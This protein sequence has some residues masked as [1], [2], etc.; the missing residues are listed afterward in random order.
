MP[1]TADDT[2]LVSSS[3]CEV[4]VLIEIAQKDANIQ[5]YSFN[6]QKTQVMVVNQNPNVP[7]PEVKLN[8]V[9]ISSTFRRDTLGLSATIDR[10]YNI[11]P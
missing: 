10:H 6:T 5:R 7:S 1:T 11:M 8:K 3:Y 2:A 9:N 4:K